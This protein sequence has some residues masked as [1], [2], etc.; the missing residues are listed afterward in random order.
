MRIVLATPLYPPDIA[1]PAPYIKELAARLAPHHTVTVVTYG[2]L[3][4][5]VPGVSIVAVRKRLPLALRLFL[6][7]VAL[8]KAA[9]RA[10]VL[11]AQNGASVELSVGIVARLM[12]RPLIMQLGDKAAHRYAAGRPLLRTIE[13][14]ATSRAKMVEHAPA[15]RPE[16]L[17]FE[18]APTEALAAYEASWKAHVAE[19]E[20]IFDHAY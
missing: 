1:E 11:Y 20:R 5:E 19:L 15:Q 6:Y 13:R 3:P 9:Y 7:T 18:P 10:D 14:F 4:E 12:R 8:A 17:P 16:V 2:H